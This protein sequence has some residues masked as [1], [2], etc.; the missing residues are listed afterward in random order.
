MTIENFIR[1]ALYKPND[2]IAYHV[3][4]ELA[5]L[6]PGST[7]LEGE[8]SYFDIESFVRAQKCAIVEHKSVFHHV[9]TEWV[10]SGKLK[11][12]IKNSW[13][14]VLWKG[15]L[16]DVVLITWNES[17]HRHRYYWIVSDVPGRAASTA[18]TTST[19]QPSRNASHTSKS[20]TAS[21]K[22]IYNCRKKARPRW[23]AQPTAS[24][25]RT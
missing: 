22:Q 10:A 1:D 15:Q 8:T 5:Q 20:G 19:C 21:C 13:L 24:R 14:N 16:I 7:V 25:S 6:H 17:C 11:Q 12:H 2:Y 3:G 9:R 23:S 18:S 4:R